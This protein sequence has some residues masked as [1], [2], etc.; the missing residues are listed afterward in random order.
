VVAPPPVLKP[1]AKQTPPVQT[2]LA[3]PVVEKGWQGVRPADAA[4]LKK[5]IVQQN[6]PPKD[7]PKPTPLPTP[8]ILKKGQAVVGDTIYNKAYSLEPGKI[9]RVNREPDEFSEPCIALLWFTQPDKIA[10]LFGNE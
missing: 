3:N 1:A 9:N 8:Q 2:R 6:P 7:L 5:T 10:T 4:K